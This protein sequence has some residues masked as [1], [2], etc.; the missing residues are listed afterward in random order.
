MCEGRRFHFPL[1][2]AGLTQNVAHSPIVIPGYN[3]SQLVVSAVEKKK[4]GKKRGKKK[5][6]LI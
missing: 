4:N 6:P 3:H 5:N 2:C 1:L